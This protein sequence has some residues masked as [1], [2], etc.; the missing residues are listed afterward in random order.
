MSDW[1]DGAGNGTSVDAVALLDADYAS[2]LWEIVQAGALLSI[3]TTSDGGALGITI[4]VDGRW[5]REY[6]RDS[7][8]IALWLSEAVPAVKDAASRRSASR[9]PR[10]RERRSRG[11]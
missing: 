10:S 5:R 1:F 9:E 4:T 3:S 8:A 7:E 2:L 6:F 11:L